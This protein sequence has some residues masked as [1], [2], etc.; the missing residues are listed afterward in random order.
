MSEFEDLMSKE[1]LTEEDRTLEACLLDFIKVVLNKGDLS[2]LQRSFN[3]KIVADILFKLDNEEFSDLISSKDWLVRVKSRLNNFLGKKGMNIEVQCDVKKLETA[4]FDE[5][6]HFLIDLIAMVKVFNPPLYKVVE[7]NMD[8]DKFYFLDNIIQDSVGHLS[9]SFQQNLNMNMNMNGRRNGSIFREIDEEG[10]NKELMQLQMDR[11]E[12]QTLIGK[13]RA[14][15]SDKSLEIINIRNDLRKGGLKSKALETD[16][17]ERCE[18]RIQNVT[19][20]GDLMEEVKKLKIDNKKLRDAG[21]DYLVQEEVWVGKLHEK[22]IKVGNL[23]REV[24]ALEQSINVY[25]LQLKEFAKMG[26]R[27]KNEKEEFKRLREVVVAL[28][29]GNREKNQMLYYFHYTH[30]QLEVE[31]LKLDHYIKL[32][33]IQIQKLTTTEKELIH[34]NEILKALNQNLMQIGQT[35]GPSRPNLKYASVGNLGQRDIEADVAQEKLIRLLKD[36][37]RVSLTARP[38]SIYKYRG[39]TR[40]IEDA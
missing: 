36:N 17:N 20:I 5:I 32:C 16:L 3:E 40:L 38:K 11:L 19:K 27:F 8:P 21:A 18:E 2:S 39:I 24:V 1:I 9:E 13:L 7:G 26:V 15:L 23:T 4:D 10:E 29:R 35:G 31:K 34:E 33:Q 30:H 28:K 12:T 25:E 14:E 6:C 22:E 37:I